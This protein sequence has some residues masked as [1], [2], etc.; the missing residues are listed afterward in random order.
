MNYVRVKDIREELGITAKGLDKAIERYNIKKHYPHQKNIPY[1]L[2]SDAS[3][4]KNH[5]NNN[6]RVGA[7]LNRDRSEAELLE[8]N[9]RLSA[10][11]T[12]MNS[13]LQSYKDKISMLTEDKITHQN[14]INK[15][16]EQAIE[17]QERLKESNQLL[18]LE[19]AESERFKKLYIEK[20]NLL[21]QAEE[22]KTK[23]ISEK[24]NEF[25]L[26][27]KE[28]SEQQNNTKELQNKLNE[29]E[30]MS[31]FSLIKKKWFKK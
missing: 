10:E 26:L 21:L 3:A 18:L 13:N 30:N 15:L 8:E 22:D 27:K 12:I 31:I 17:Y 25:I 9:K 11:L 4:L 1:L 16:N 24:E 19:K 7:L 28:L 23:Y 5:I 6:G 14:Q 2:E 20:R 29:L